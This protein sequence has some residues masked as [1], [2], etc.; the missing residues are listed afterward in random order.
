M[1]KIV[2][3]VM[4]P[5]DGA[6]NYDRE[7]AYKLGQLIAQQGWVLLTG[8]RKVGVMEY[9]MQ[10]AK[11]VGGLTIGIL[12]DRDRKQISEAVDIPIITDLGNG[13]NNINVLS[14]D[15]VIACGLGLGT[16]SEIALALK[17]GKKVV[18]LTDNELGLKFFSSLA[19][20]RIS[21]ANSAREA[22]NIVKS[23]VVN[24]PKSKNSG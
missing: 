17:N 2:I 14:S 12:P 18:L 16:V 8:G 3:G 19:E 10:G 4:G 22:I 11:S 21:V 24:I 20:N 15:V 7:N 13:R 9:A 5:G 6:S 1:K 23:M